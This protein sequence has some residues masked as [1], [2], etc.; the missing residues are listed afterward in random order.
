[1][2]CSICP[3]NC[4]AD[5]SVNT[6]VC[7][8]GDKIKIARA[9]PH[10]WEEPCLSGENGSGTVFFSGCNLGCVFCQ[11]YD[12]SHRAY[13]A[14]LSDIQLM[15][16]F[17]KLI[18][19][20]VHNLNLVTPSHYV[21]Q[22]ARVLREYKS[23]VPI[24]Y[25]SSGYEKADTLKMLEGLIDIYLPDIKYFDSAPALKY[26]GAADY[27]EYASSAVLEMY[28]QVGG[29]QLDENG[30]AKKGII[31]RHLVLPGNISQ[32]VKVFGWVRDN[33]PEDTY[34]SVMRQ[35]TPFGKATEMPPVNRR[36]SSR[37]Y[38]IVKQ[39][40]LAMGFENCYFQ[41][42]ESAKESFIPNFNLEGVDL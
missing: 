8:A 39:K 10:Y 25:N 33:L 31:I 6:G 28:R 18:E 14:E 22:L 34:I 32:A 36:L 41:S 5:R 20:G 17:D 16:T 30:I 29:V 2:K 9:A 40:I 42:P 26:S 38:A 4:G 13:G 35:Y 24:V 21:P 7:G 27:F 15:R 23:P 37:E 12:V 1:M 19:K 11:N 3:R